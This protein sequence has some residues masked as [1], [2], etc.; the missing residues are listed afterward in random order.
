MRFSELRLNVD[1]HVG[2]YAA[3]LRVEALLLFEAETV[4]LVRL[5]Y[6]LSP[7]EL[8]DAVARRVLIV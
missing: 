3:M 1:R 4:A 6:V 2:R 8:V 7:V 5:K